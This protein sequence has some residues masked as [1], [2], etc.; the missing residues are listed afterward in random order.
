[1][2]P[3]DLGRVINNYHCGGCEKIR[4]SF[5]FFI[6]NIFFHKIIGPKIIKLIPD[7]FQLTSVSAF[8]QQH[9]CVTA[10][11][12]LL[13]NIIATLFFTVNA[14]VITAMKL[15]RIVSVSLCNVYVKIYCSMS[16]V[17]SLINLLSK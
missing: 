7:L 3:I 12:D 4:K 9:F 15:K 13:A 16:F 1:M 5:Q 17:A 14:M 6:Q 8:H 11:A 10:E 2:P